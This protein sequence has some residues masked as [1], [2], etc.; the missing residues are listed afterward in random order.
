MSHISSLPSVDDSITYHSGGTW[1]EASSASISTSQGPHRHIPPR[2][3]SGDPNSSP[4]PTAS[5]TSGT[6]GPTDNG[7][8]TPSA[9]PRYQ[10]NQKK[11]TRVMS[12]LSPQELW[13]K[14]DKTEEEKHVR[15]ILGNRISAQDKRTRKMN[16]LATLEQS[17]KDMESRL[18][19]NLDTVEALKQ[20]REL[21]D[22][23]E[24]E[25]EGHIALL[26]W[27]I[28][29]MESMSQE[30]NAVNSMAPAFSE[31]YLQQPWL[32]PTMPPQGDNTLWTGPVDLADMTD[33]SYIDP[34]LTL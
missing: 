34:D 22:L 20:C 12:R 26:E 23:R 13:D 18:S 3:T 30:A 31:S 28:S 5:T 17:I 11:I 2:R 7:R 9:R 32:S 14:P 8:K 21:Q 29:T 27:R 33:E 16:A 19:H 24:L 15:Q 1:P 6:N 25:R 4:N 10:E